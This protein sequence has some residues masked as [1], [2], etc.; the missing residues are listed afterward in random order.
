MNFQSGNHTEGSKSWE[1]K[2]Y[3]VKLKKTTECKGKK[4]KT[5]IQY[6]IRTNIL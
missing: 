2:D 3:S 6:K 1:N 4:H 5:P